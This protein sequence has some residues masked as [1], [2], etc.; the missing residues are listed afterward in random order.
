MKTLSKTVTG[1]LAAALLTTAV[2]SPAEAQ[3]YRRHYDRGNGI[4]LGDV[5]LGTI[6][7][8]GVAA[9]VGALSNNNRDRYEDGRYDDG[10]YGNRGYGR[11]QQASVDACAY[12]AEREAGRRFGGRAQVRDIDVDRSRN[13]YRVRGTVEVQ[14][15]YGRGGYDRGGYDRGGY[16]RGDQRVQFSCTANGSRVTGLNVGSNYAYRGG[17][18]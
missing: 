14:S 5:V 6:V 13:G 8:G 12:E 15:D 10:R 3:R 4:S 17:G 1:A 11:G 18:Y 2:A 9:A 16:D 7:V